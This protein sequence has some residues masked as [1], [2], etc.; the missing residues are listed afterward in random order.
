MADRTLVIILAVM[1]RLVRQ[2]QLAALVVQLWWPLEGRADRE[3]TKT[4]SKKV[5]LVQ[6]PL[7]IHHRTMVGAGGYGL[8]IY[9]SSTGVEDT[10]QVLMNRLPHPVGY[11]GLG[12]LRTPT[13]ELDEFN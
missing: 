2:R 10:P 3:F 1:A 12:G 9:L 4:L 8:L 13:Q 11:M 7:W 5:I 6:A